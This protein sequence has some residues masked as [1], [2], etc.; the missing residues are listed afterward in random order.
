MA[1]EEAVLEL[2]ETMKTL[3]QVI[4][5]E[6]PKKKNKN[7]EKKNQSKVTEKAESPNLEDVRK[8]LIHLK[9]ATDS[10]SAKAVL[11]EFNAKKLN[12]LD[13]KDY[14]QCIDLCLAKE[15]A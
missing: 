8:A 10:Q 15:A 2:N 7:T 4:Q 14:Q 11:A 5:D 6:K 13:E 3:I 12:E 1:L 9:N